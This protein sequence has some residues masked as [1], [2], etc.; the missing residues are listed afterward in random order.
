MV[1][2]ITPSCCPLIS[3]GFT[4]GASLKKARRISSTTPSTRPRTGFADPGSAL[5]VNGVAVATLMTTTGLVLTVAAIPV[6]ALAGRFSAERASGYS[7]ATETF[8]WASAG[9]LVAGRRGIPQVGAISADVRALTTRAKTPTGVFR[10]VVPAAR[11]ADAECLDRPTTPLPDLAG[12]ADTEAPSESPLS[13]LATPSTWGPANPSPIRNAAAPTRTPQ[14][15]IDTETPRF[16]PPSAAPADCEKPEYRLCGNLRDSNKNARP[17]ATSDPS[18]ELPSCY[19]GIV[20][21]PHAAR[22][23][24]RRVVDA[25]AQLHRAE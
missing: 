7:P 21:P 16:V 2:V 25:N 13:A 6:V 18:V 15:T 4:V 14:L 19:G 1:P 5:P 23:W 3:T 24:I 9:V 17:T 12:P 20:R 10:P 11:G 22:L 8:G